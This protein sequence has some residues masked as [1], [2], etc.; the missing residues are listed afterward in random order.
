MS[1]SRVPEFRSPT[2]VKFHD[3]ALVRT[4]AAAS[5]RLISD[6][7]RHFWSISESE[8]TLDPIEMESAL[9]SFLYTSW[10]LFRVFLSSISLTSL[11][12]S[13]W[14]QLGAERPKQWRR[15]QL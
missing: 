15:A 10:E 1:T 3:W 7:Q 2:F 12:V 8:Q 14:S 5:H 13:A 6:S 11:D 4:F 9:S